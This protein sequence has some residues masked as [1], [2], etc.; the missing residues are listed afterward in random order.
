MSQVQLLPPANG[1][2]TRVNGR[3]YTAQPG[4]VI[5]APDEDAAE[6]EANGW[7]RVAE[8]AGPS[9]QRPQNPAAGFE[10]HDQTLGR[11]IRFDGK[12]WRDPDTGAGV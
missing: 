4:G 12:T 8:A 5:V 6:L 10:F 3:L 2:S 7:I 1:A 9:A 11:N